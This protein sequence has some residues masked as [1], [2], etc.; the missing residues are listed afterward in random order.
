M[1][2]RLQIR[3]P[4]QKYTTATLCLYRSSYIWTFQAPYLPELKFS[5]FDY[6]LVKQVFTG[7]AGIVTGTNRKGGGPALKSPPLFQ[8]VGLYG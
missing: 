1:N 7:D 2:E 5:A 8:S 3:Y 4:L 6:D